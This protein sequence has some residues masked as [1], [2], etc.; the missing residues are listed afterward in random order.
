M[1]IKKGDTVKVISGNAKGKI[2]T[3][4]KVLVKSERVIVDGVKI[5]SHHKKTF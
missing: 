5:V 4:T 1:Y 3:V 2:G